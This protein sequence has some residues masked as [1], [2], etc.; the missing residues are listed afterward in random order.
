M[1]HGAPLNHLLFVFLHGRSITALHNG[2]MGLLAAK[3]D[4]SEKY[5]SS[6]VKVLLL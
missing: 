5:N 3:A 1:G 2:G 6:H 4:L